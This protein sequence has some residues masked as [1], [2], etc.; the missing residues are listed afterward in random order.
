MSSE[1]KLVFISEGKAYHDKPEW[2]EIG[3]TKAGN[4]LYT[5]LH[6]AVKN[7]F[8]YR[9]TAGTLLEG[10]RVVEYKLVPTGKVYN[11]LGEEI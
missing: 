3:G 11:S 2:V 9:S 6:N 1:N 7:L 5:K 8:G 10:K 4:K